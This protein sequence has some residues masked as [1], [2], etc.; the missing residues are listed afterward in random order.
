MCLYSEATISPPK[1]HGVQSVFWE[2]EVYCTRCRKFTRREYRDPGCSEHVGPFTRTPNPER[3]AAVHTRPSCLNRPLCMIDLW[4]ETPKTVHLPDRAKPN[5][6]PSLN[7]MDLPD[8]DG[9]WTMYGQTRPPRAEHFPNPGDPD[10]KPYVEQHEG[11]R[12]IWGPKKQA[13]DQAVQEWLDVQNQAYN[14]QKIENAFGMHRVD[15]LGERIQRLPDGS[16]SEDRHL[17]QHDKP[18]NV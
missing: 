1:D 3:N 5:N 2:S 9:N 10:H 18:T 6:P 13:M 7:M 11:N 12:H 8:K 4:G 17:R 16:Y 14:R 15:E